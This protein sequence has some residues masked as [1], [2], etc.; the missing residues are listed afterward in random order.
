MKKFKDNMDFVK[1]LANEG[2]EKTIV[3]TV[4]NGD[5][6]E[7][8]EIALECGTVCH[9]GQ[10]VDYTPITIM[11]DGSRL[12]VMPEPIMTRH[13]DYE[14]TKPKTTVRFGDKLGVAV[15]TID[16]FNLDDESIEACY[17]IT[18]IKQGASLAE[19]PAVLS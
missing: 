2:V 4:V 12:H 19:Q 8:D 3:I 11:W 13:R 16:G 1:E 9:Y 17:F 18:E 6:R 10:C 15:I 7:S 5:H 14:A